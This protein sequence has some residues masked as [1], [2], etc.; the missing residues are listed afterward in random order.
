M[1]PVL[2]APL[3]N[4]S[5]SVGPRTEM[6]EAVISAKGLEGSLIY[7][8]SSEIRAGYPL[9]LDLLPD[10]SAEE[11]ASRLTRQPRKASVATALRKAL[12]LDP[13]KC[14][15]LFE[16]V[17]DRSRGGIASAVKALPLRYN[18]PAPL[19]EAISTT[20]GVA[21]SALD[22]TMLR[23]A[24][25][26]FCA[27]EMVDWDAPTG[28]YLLTACIASGRAAGRQAVDYA[29]GGFRIASALL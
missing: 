18:G 25:G 8:F 1:G 22:G 12:R 20:G 6:G 19:D 3:K 15:L 5:M 21:T 23:T 14:A 29:S 17:A 2:G 28:G 16:F 26:V 13:A 9:R 24:P 11:V 10:L 4:I 27:G 7:R